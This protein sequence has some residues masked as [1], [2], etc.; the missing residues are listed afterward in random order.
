MNQDLA[1]LLDGSANKAVAFIEVLLEVGRGNVLFV[2]EHVLILTL[3]F[4]DQSGAY[5]EDVGDAR[6]SQGK[7]IMTS[8]VVAKPDV[9][10]D[11]VLRVDF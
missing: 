7:F 3:K 10:G 8:L 6:S 1:T 2:D 9:L 4:G 5:C 11:L